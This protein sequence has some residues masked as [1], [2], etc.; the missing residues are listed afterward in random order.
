[1][2]GVIANNSRS[3]RTRGGILN[4]G[5]TIRARGD[6]SNHGTVRTKG[7]VQNCRTRDAVH[8]SYLKLNETMDDNAGS[9][10]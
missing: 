3:I 4:H 10:E 7:G 9:N 6:T 5:R 8:T 2:K 1:M